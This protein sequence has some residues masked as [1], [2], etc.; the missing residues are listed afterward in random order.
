MNTSVVVRVGEEDSAIIGQHE[1][2]FSGDETVLY[3]DCGAGG[4]YTNLYTV[5]TQNYTPVKS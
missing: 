4:S 2:V 5:K 1:E 3:S